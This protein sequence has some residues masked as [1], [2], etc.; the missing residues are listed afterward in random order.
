MLLGFQNESFH[1]EAPDGGRIIVL[2]STNGSRKVYNTLDCPRWIFKRFEY[3]KRFVDLVRS[4]TPLIVLCTDSFKAMLMANFPN[5]DFVL[6]YSK[7]DMKASFNG[8]ANL[9][10]LQNGGEQIRVPNPD[11]INLDGINSKQARL[12]MC[13]FSTRYKQCIKL[14]DSHTEGIGSTFPII[15][16]ECL[17]KKEPKTVINCKTKN[18]STIAIDEYKSTFYNSPTRNMDFFCGSTKKLFLREIGWC[19]LNSDQK[20]LLLFIDGTALI[21]DYASGR[22]AHSYGDGLNDEWAWYND[23]S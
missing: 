3:I 4:K 6:T 15:V 16:D 10:I 23:D 13:D 7:V 19:L 11:L 21:L 9:L 12:V 18:Y 5:P 1:L 2:A 14:L 20:V 17:H 22:L 8:K